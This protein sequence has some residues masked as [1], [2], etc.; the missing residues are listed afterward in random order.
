VSDSKPRCIMCGNP[1]LWPTAP[2]DLGD[3]L[4]AKLDCIAAFLEARSVR[5]ALVT[6]KSDI[7]AMV[8]EFW[9]AN[10]PL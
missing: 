7:A 2:D 10:K 1:G 5:R 9:K 4:C 3:R 6:T 8:E